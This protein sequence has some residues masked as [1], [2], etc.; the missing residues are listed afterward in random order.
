MA[1]KD[2][3]ELLGKDVVLL[4]WPIG[5]KATN[6]PWGHLTIADMTPEYLET[7]HNRNVGVVLGEKS[8]NLIHLDVDMDK[9]VEP[10]LAANPFLKRTLQTRGSRGCGFWLHMAGQ[11]PAQTVKFRTRDGRDAGEFRSN[12]SQ[13]IIYGIHPDT[14]KPYQLLNVAKP[15]EVEFQQIRWP[16][17]VINPFE[18]RK[19]T[20]ETEVIDV[21]DEAEVTDEAVDTEVISPTS[22][23]LFSLI[24][25]MEDAVQIALPTRVHE[26][27]KKTFDL[28][29]ALLTLRKKG[30]NCDPDELFE[31]W[32]TQAKPFLRPE[33]SWGDYYLE[34][35][36]ACLRAKV[37]F[38][39]SKVT[40]AWARAKQNPLPLPANVMKVQK[41]DLSLLCAFFREMQAEVGPGQVWFVAGGLRA[42]AKLLGHK[43]HSTVETWVGALIKMGVLKLVKKGDS[44]HSTR[45]LFIG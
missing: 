9:L 11:Y 10:F 16:D 26:N 39:S 12:G 43:S 7:L 38:G 4:S 6:R 19:C 37:P 1:V 14:K 44:H 2:V 34:F 36:N 18:R 29:R 13:S 8:G 20:E 5:L 33:L 23:G 15:L 35:Q 31:L 41:A 17:E 40:A 45:F 27:N 28:A 22:K 21:T 25:S 30:I 3:L 24:N 42:C 32:Y